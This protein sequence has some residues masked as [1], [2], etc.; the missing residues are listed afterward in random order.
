ME[1]HK[2][3]MYPFGYSEASQKDLK[4]LQSIPIVVWTKSLNVFMRARWR[5][6]I[7]R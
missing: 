7:K 2:F 1:N 5:L 3:V 6:Y 4:T